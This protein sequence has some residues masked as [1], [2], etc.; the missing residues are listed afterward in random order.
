VLLEQHGQQHDLEGQQVGGVC[1]GGQVVAR[2]GQQFVEDLLVLAA[3]RTAKARQRL[4]LLKEG[5]G[6]GW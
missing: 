3:Q 1:S 6:D 5:L 4:L 2:A